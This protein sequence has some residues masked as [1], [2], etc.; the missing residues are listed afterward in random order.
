MMLRFGEQHNGSPSEAPALPRRLR[1]QRQP[2]RRGDAADTAAESGT[3]RQSGGSGGSTCAFSDLGKG[4]ALGSDCQS[5]LC[6]GLTPSFICTRA[7]T[8]TND[9][10]LNWTCDAAT[11]G[12]KVCMSGKTSGTP[13]TSSVCRSVTYSDI[14]GPCTS[15]C[16]SKYCVGNACTR[17]CDV[18]SDCGSSWTCSAGSDSFKSCR[19]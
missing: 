13:S 3:E 4:C 11:G 5:N 1:T 2:A 12:G 19:P 17:R 16:L 10:P 9:C 15:N 8:T 14:G 7:C 18:N 6:F